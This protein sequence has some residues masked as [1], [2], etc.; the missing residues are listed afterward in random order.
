MTRKWYDFIGAGLRLLREDLGLTGP[1]I[2]RQRGMASITGQANYE[3]SYK[4]TQ[5]G[6]VWFDGKKAR[7]D[8]HLD[9]RRE[10]K[11]ATLNDITDAMSAL[12]QC[13]VRVEDVM[14]RARAA[15]AEHEEAVAVACL[16]TGLGRAEWLAQVQEGKWLSPTSR[17][18]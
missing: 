7:R 8:G 3:S 13:P 6:R 12:A 16:V 17:T 18:S 1:A 5:F 10:V 4:R 15:Y 11:L 14:E 2:C 9:Q